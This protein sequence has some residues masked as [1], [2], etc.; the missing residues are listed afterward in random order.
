VRKLGK[1]LVLES[2]IVQRPIVR[3]ILS[4]N[5]NYAQIIRS[6][7]TWVKHLIVPFC[8]SPKLKNEKRKSL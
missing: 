7:K 3:K 2:L 1:I 4:N 5:R 6:E 8:V